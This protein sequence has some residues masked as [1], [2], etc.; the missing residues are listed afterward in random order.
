MMRSF[1]VGKVVKIPAEIKAADI[2]R[3]AIV[4]GSIAPGSRI[5]EGDLSE[6]MQLSR[7]T[8]RSA[9][10]QLAGEGLTTLKRYAGWSVVRLSAVDVWELYTVRSTMERLSARLVAAKIDAQTTSA[11]RKALA[12][13]ERQCRGEAW[14]KIADADFKFHKAIVELAGNERLAVQYASIESQIR[15]Y[16]RSLDCLLFEPP[17]LVAQHERIA[18]AIIS[19]N[20]ADAGDLAEAHNLVDGESLA[21]HLAAQELNVTHIDP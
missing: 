17:T 12:H 5:T 11:I 1:N 14:D 15:M 16:I 2:L 3:D 13:L 21:R 9:L 6:K 20:V 7:A 19:G 8:I 18:D 10:Q 4:N